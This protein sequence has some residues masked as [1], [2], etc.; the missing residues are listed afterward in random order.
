[1]RS[2]GVPGRSLFVRGFGA[3]RVGLSAGGRRPVSIAIDR[4]LIEQRLPPWSD[5]VGT[6]QPLGCLLLGNRGAPLA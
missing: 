2:T 6:L 3:A 4:L 5:Q 1:V